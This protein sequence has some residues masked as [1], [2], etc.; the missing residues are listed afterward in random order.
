METIA[1]KEQRNTWPRL[2]TLT[3]TSRYLGLAPSTLRNQHTPS[4]PG[5]R[6]PGRIE[7]NGRAKYDRAVIDAWIDDLHLHGE[8]ETRDTPSEESPSEESPA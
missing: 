6:V 5:T 7:I 8:G 4:F 3:E 1:N 2:L